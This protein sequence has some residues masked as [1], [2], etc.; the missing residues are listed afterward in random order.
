MNHLQI[1]SF[2]GKTG[3]SQYDIIEFYPI[4]AKEL[5]LKS[6]NYIRKFID[7]IEEQKEIILTWRKS[8]ITDYSTRFKNCTDNFNIFMGAYVH[9]RKNNWLDRY[10]YSRE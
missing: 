6:L 5:I 7:I 8:I 1:V 10:L 9:L 4:I 2:K 3:F